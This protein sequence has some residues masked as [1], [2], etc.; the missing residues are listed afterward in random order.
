MAWEIL[1][2][3]N[4]NIDFDVLLDKY[5]ELEIKKAREEMKEKAL[6]LTDLHGDYLDFILEL[7]NL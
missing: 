6:R 3:Q 7:R 5:I 1:R 2:T 4:E